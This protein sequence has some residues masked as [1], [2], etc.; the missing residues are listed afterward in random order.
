[1]ADIF[2]S[3]DGWLA[4]RLENATGMSLVN[5]YKATAPCAH[6]P[7]PSSAPTPECNS[8]E[9]ARSVE[10][11]RYIPG[12]HLPSAGWY[13]PCVKC[14]DLTARCDDDEVYV[15]GRCANP[16]GKR[17]RSP[18]ADSNASSLDGFPDVVEE[19]EVA[20]ELKLPT[21]LPRP[22]S[23]GSTENLDAAAEEKPASGNMPAAP[24]DNDSEDFASVC[25]D[26]P[27]PAAAPST[28]H[29]P[30]AV[31]TVA[32]ISAGATAAL[33]AVLAE[34]LDNSATSLW[35]WPCNAPQS[36]S[37]PATQPAR[38]SRFSIK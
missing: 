9:W 36:N 2:G 19:E 32:E 6:Q 34:F 25:L 8:H 21:R 18:G 20:T 29:Q 12:T 31:G 38:N 10:R 5:A 7:Q 14:R 17:P 16:G 24:G 26:S 11:S 15:C 37:R 13:Q 30:Q 1:M 27:V 28:D 4:R 33:D 3:P 35:C 22:A 23:D